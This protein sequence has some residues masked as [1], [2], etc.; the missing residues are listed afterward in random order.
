M[1]DCHT[2]KS[3]KSIKGAI[4]ARL[5]LVDPAWIAEGRSVLLMTEIQG[6]KGVEIV[7]LGRKL[8]VFQ[9]RQLKY[10]LLSIAIQHTRES[11]QS[12]CGFLLQFFA[13]VVRDKE[14]MHVALVSQSVLAVRANWGIKMVL[15][16]LDD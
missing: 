11:L 6:D 2:L 8:S 3:A 1:G 14:I 13:Q 5:S 10:R 7:H 9:V 16:L 4:F 12:S 15:N